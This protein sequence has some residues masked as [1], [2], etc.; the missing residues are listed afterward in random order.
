LRILGTL[1]DSSIFVNRAPEGSRIYRV[2]IG[3]R[4]DPEAVELT[5]DQLREIVSRELRQVWG[6]FEEPTEVGV[7]RHP[8]GISQ[9]E[10]GH[11][12]LVDR[13]EAACPDWL[14]LAGSSYRGVALNACVKEALDWTP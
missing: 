13:I 6:S 2:L 12:E 10:I 4:R 3:G 1:Y 8:L 5:D 7:V 9:Y 14:R 11:G